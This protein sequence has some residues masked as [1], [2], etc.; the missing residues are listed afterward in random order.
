MEST[1][2]NLNRAER[3]TVSQTMREAQ[4]QMGGLH[5]AKRPILASH[6][7]RET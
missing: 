7:K 1:I 2:T 4:E 5:K 3:W 6:K